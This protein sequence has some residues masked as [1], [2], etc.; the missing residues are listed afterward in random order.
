MAE[1]PDVKKVWLGF[2]ESFT[3]GDTTVTRFGDGFRIDTP[4]EMDGNTRSTHV[5][6]V[7]RMGFARH[8]GP[9]E[10]YHFDPSPPP[11]PTE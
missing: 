4:G 9:T 5:D 7:F 10:V 6:G 8:D 11:N 3:H 2:Y 1:G